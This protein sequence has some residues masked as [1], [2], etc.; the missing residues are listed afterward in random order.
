MHSSP[1]RYLW[2]PLRAAFIK[3]R[4]EYRHYLVD[5]VVGLLLKLLFFVAMLL[6]YPAVDPVGN[7]ARIHGFVLWY[8]AAH[9]LAKMSNMVLEE[10]YLGTFLQV[11][12]ARTPLFLFLAAHSIAEIV[13]SSLWIGL[14]LVVGSVLTPFWKGVGLLSPGQGATIL[15]VVLITLAGLIGMGFFLFGLSILFKVV[16]SITELLIFAMLFFSG[17][18][19]PLSTLPRLLIVLGYGSP[20]WWSFTLLHRVFQG[21]GVG[22]GLVAHAGV[23]VV[24][25]ALGIAVSSY[26]LKLAK[27]RGTLAAY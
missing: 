5:Y 1:V 4:G 18:F 26:T 27:T 6:A 25:A 2:W 23:A 12:T 24:W 8:F 9:I 14:F 13:M 21:E 10:A 17:F 20:L 7:L 11:L 22:F 3:K 19:I 16:G 15:L